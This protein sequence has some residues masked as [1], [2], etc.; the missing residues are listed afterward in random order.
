MYAVEMKNVIKN[1][2]PFKLCLTDFTLPMGC[3]LGLVGEN[4]AGKTTA[5]KLIL[6]MIRRDGGQITVLGRDNRENFTLTKQEIGVVLDE[7]GIPQCLFTK[8]VDRI[9]SLTFQAWDSPYFH[10]LL[11]QLGVPENKPFRAFS[12]GT[13][14]KLGLAI[15]LAH[16]PRLLLLDEAT[17]GLDPVARDQVM[18]LLMEFTREEDHSVLVSSHIVSDLE[19]ICDYIA[20]LHRGKLLLQEEKDYLLG[21]YG[22]LHCTK[23]QLAKLDP[24]AI[25]GARHL[26]YESQALVIRRM[27]PQGLT[28]SPVNL[29]ELFLFLVKEAA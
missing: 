8:Q 9:M 6:D 27:I 2:G 3:I 24:K 26:P 29:E 1:Y 11:S 14:M 5:I 18:G 17:S 19:K 23:E 4:G 16:R 13:K 10:Q 22:L 28:V 15:A 25:K 21:E 7:V 20:F 12:K